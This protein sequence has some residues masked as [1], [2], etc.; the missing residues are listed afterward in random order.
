M[1]SHPDFYDGKWSDASAAKGVSAILRQRQIVRY[2]EQFTSASELTIVDL[3]CGKGILAEALAAFGRVIG[4]D[5]ASQTIRDNQTRTPHVNF[6]QG[7]VA[8]RALPSRLG[9]HDVVVSSEVIEHLRIEARGP[10]LRNAFELLRPDGLLILTTP[11]KEVML[12]RKNPGESDSDFMARIDNQ[13]INN[14]MTKEELL[15]LVTP[16]FEVM[17]FTSVQPLIRNR[18]VD[19]F[20]KALFLPINYRFVNDLTHF[21]G[22]RGQYMVLVGRKRD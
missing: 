1:N 3:G 14:L 10:F 15:G 5:F 7:D 17:A 8:D 16:Q 19:L 2:I 4:V 18:A 11:Y 6:I 13:P 9:E 21:I 12:S 22:L 20:C